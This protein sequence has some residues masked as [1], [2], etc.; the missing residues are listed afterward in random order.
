MVDIHS[1]ILPGWDDGSRS[2]AE[3]LEMLRIAVDSGTTDIV[4]TPHANSEF[5]FQ[6]DVVNRIFSELQAAADG[7][8]KL[9]LGCDFHVQFENVQD[10]LRNPTKYT[11]NHGA[12][13]MVE[14]PEV[15]SLPVIRDILSRLREVGIV[16]VITHPE[17]NTHLQG[18]RDS[19]ELARWVEEGTLLQVTGQSLLGRFGNLAQRCAAGLMKGD[20]VHFIASDAHDAKDRTP[21]LAEA[22]GWVESRYGR[23]RAE[24]LFRLNPAAAVSGSPIERVY[25]GDEQ[26]EAKKWWA[27][28]K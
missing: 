24:R 12:Y 15:M 25:A 22:F 20:L 19:T 10:A 5:P 28:W 18:L 26:N 14:L 16:P 17:R 9:H 21:R 3:S 4:A 1:H 7:T 6:P 13:L 11:I 2:M 23:S 8:I 27:F